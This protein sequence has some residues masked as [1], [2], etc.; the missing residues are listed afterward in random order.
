MIKRIKYETREV[1]RFP[2]VKRGKNIL[3]DL[4]KTEI[5][6]WLNSQIVSYGSLRG[7]ALMSEKLAF[8]LE[9]MAY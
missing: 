1:T 2:E 6:V 8:K 7:Q 9:S 5:C 3:C 4:G